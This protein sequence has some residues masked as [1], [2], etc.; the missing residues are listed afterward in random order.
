M[1]LVC[2]GSTPPRNLVRILRC[3]DSPTR[4]SIIHA[5][6]PVPSV[7]DLV[8]HRLA[9]TRNR[10]GLIVTERVLAA[11]RVVLAFS[12]LLLVQLAPETVQPYNQ[13]ILALVLLYLAHA[14]WLLFVVNFRAEIS[15]R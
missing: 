14:T 11:V 12:S 3:N 13:L 10:R 15:P 9:L 2:S 8:S 6:R 4:W 5:M 7:L 1:E